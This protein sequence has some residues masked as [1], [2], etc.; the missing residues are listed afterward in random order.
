MLGNRTYKTYKTHASDGKQSC[1]ARTSYLNGDKCTKS[2]RLAPFL[3]GAYGAD[4][5]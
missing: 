1:K 4:Y 2:P 3:I 5:G